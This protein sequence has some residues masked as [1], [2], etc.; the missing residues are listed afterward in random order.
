M[1]QP[2]ILPACQSAYGLRIRSELALP[3]LGPALAAGEPDVTIR[4]G[5]IDRP[6]LAVAP[7]SKAAFDVRP[8]EA[9]FFYPLAGKFLIRAGCEITLAPIEG[10]DAGNLRF[11]TLGVALGITLHMRGRLALHASAVVVN[12]R[13]VAFL[14]ES[15][16]G[17][18]TLAARLLR[19]GHTLLTD[20]VLA[21]SS[22]QGET[23]AWPGFPQLKL[24]PDALRDMGDDPEALPTL[25]S[26]SEKRSYRLQ[27]RFAGGS[28]PL[29]RIYVLGGGHAISSTPLEPQQAFQELAG[30]TYA[31]RFIGA[32]GSTAEHLR[33]CAHLVRTVQIHRLR[34][35]YRLDQLDAVAELIEREMEG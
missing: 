8:G 12:G 24:W 32:A 22:D 27:E 6:P 17:K 14:G 35:P 16:E 15:G 3:E 33:Q 34:R 25:L 21:L 19:R 7:D 11:L 23:R 28:L 29:Q 1:N 26:V 30:N 18:S 9:Y 2:P 13:A 10:A 4:L 20:D 5:M 31:L